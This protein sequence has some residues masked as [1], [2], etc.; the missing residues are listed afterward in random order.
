MTT[1]FLIT[2]YQ[3]SLLF[4]QAVEREWE[5][6]NFALQN[7]QFCPLHPRFQR[8]A[9]RGQYQDVQALIFQIKQ[10]CCKHRSQSNL[11]SPVTQATTT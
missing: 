5:G 9:L 6:G 4:C 11:S 2:G 3:H 7:T 1:P 10:T 8:L